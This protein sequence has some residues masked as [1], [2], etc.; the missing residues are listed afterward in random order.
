M[1]EVYSLPDGSQVDLSNYS[2]F[3]RINFLMENPNAKKLKG[4]A[5]SAGVMPKKKAQNTESKQ[6]S[7]SSG[8]QKYRLANEDDLEIMQKR[9]D[10]PPP[11]TYRRSNADINDLYGAQT[12]F[13]KDYQELKALLGKGD[14]KQRLGS[15]PEQKKVKVSKPEEIYDLKPNSTEHVDSLNEIARLKSKI[16]ETDSDLDHPYLYYSSKKQNQ[17][18]NFIDENYSRTEL[19]GLGVNTEDFDGFLN[20]NGYKQDYLDK[21]ERGLFSGQ[22]SNFMTGYDYKL[23][24]ELAKKRMLNL[25]MDNM[26]RRDYT[27]Q[28]LN[29]EIE[30]V[31]GNIKEK[32]IINR[33]L[34]DQNKTAK[35]IENNFP[36]VAQKLKDRDAENAK[37]YEESKK[38]SSDFWSWDTP[39]KIGRAGWYGMIDRLDQVSP[40]VYE[41]LGMTDVAEGI[42][43][44]AEQTQLSRPDNRGF[45]YASGKLVKYNG[46][47]YIV[48]S[49]GQVYDKDAKIR[50]TDLL[51][52]ST[53]EKI[54]SDSKY[55]PSDWAF[56]GQGAA[57]QT[58]N[59]MGDMIIQ[60]ALT[61]GVGQFGAIATETRLA[62][63][64]AQRA[65]KFS[66]F[67]NDTSN[68]LKMI[69]LQR[70]EGYSMIAQ[71]ALGY[72]QGY[73]ETLKA[74]RENGIT[75]G[76]A[77]KLASSAAQRLAVLYSVTGIINPQ[78]QV[79]ENLFGPKNIIKKAIDQYTKQG[80]KGFMQYLDDI[81]K[82]APKNMIG[83]AEEGGKEVIQENIQQVGEIGANKITNLEAGKKIMNEVMSG[84]D[85]VNTSILSFLSSGLISKMK[86]PDFH[87]PDENID[88][89]TSLST[90]AKNKKEFTK[91]IDGLVNQKVFTVEQADN[92]KKDVDIYADN[93]NKL[94]KTITPEAAMPVMRELDKIT[95]LENEKKSVDKAFHGEIDDKIDEIRQKI[96]DIQY[97]S[98]LKVKNK[99]IADAIKKGVAKGIEMKTF[100]STEETK[101]YLMNELNMPEK[102]ANDYLVNPGFALNS[103]TLKKYS[104]DADSISDKS[105]VIV[106]NESKTRD[107]GVI[108]HEFLH[109]V[110]QNTLK[111]NPEAQKLIG[112]AL[113]NELMKM[114]DALQKKGSKDSPVSGMFMQRLKQYIDKSV[115]LK[116]KE[117]ASYEIKLRQADGDPSKIAALK[118]AHNDMLNKIDGVMWEE[119]LTTYSDA[120]RRGHIKYEESTFTKLGD[121]IR[122][123][124][125]YLGIK[126]I[127]FNSG[128]DVYNFLKDYNHSVETGNWGKALTKMSNEG[129][130]INI[131]KE[132]KE[133]KEVSKPKEGSNFT[134]VAKFSL[135]ERKSSEDIKRDVNKTYNKEAWSTGSNSKDENPVIN[136]VMYDILNEYDYI[137]KGKAKGLGYANL[138]DFSEMD[139][140]SETQL[141][142]IPLIRNF[143]KEFFQKREE[144]KKELEA[145]GLD[146]NSKEFKDKVE[147]Q[148]EK[149]YQG[150]KGIVK[151][152]TDLNAYIN[153]QLANK[154]KD[155]LKT[156]NVTS[157]IFAE[158]IQGE[159]FKEKR[160]QDDFAGESGEESTFLDDSDSVFDAEQDFADEQRGLA[161]LLSDP[162]FK[163][164]DE[165]GKQ[166]DIETVPFGGFFVTEASDPTVAANRKLKTETDPVKIADLNRQIRDLD[167]GLQLQAKKDLTFEEKEELKALKS[168]KSYDL[169]T[170]MMVNTFEAL[171]MP[172]TPAKIISDEVGRE[173][174]RS[175]NIETLEYRNFKERLSTLSKTMARRMTF[176][177]GP[178][179]ESFMYDK[180]KL[181]Y[182][183]INHPVDP[184]TGESSY[185]SK[186]LP[187][188]LKEQD[189]KGD[190]RKIKDISRVKFLQSF[191]G[192][193]DATRIIKIYG[194]ENAAEELK[195]LEE[196]EVSEKDGG[197][198]RPTTYFDRRTALMELFGDVMVLQEARR[199]LR[200]PD[201]LERVA[202]RNV[203]LYNELKDDIIRAKVLNDMA[204]GKSDI[205]KFSLVEEI[206]VRPKPDYITANPSNMIG[207]NPMYSSKYEELFSNP[208]DFI[209]FSLAEIEEPAPEP[210]SKFK[211][212]LSRI[213]TDELEDYE[214]WIIKALQQSDIQDDDV[215]T[216][217][218]HT[219]KSAS[220]LNKEIEKRYSDLFDS[221]YDDYSENE[222]VIKEYKEGYIDTML[223]RSINIPEEEVHLPYWT[224]MKN[225]EKFR[226]K[227][228]EKIQ[229]QQEKA[230][231]QLADTTNEFDS[232]D[233][234]LF[235]KYL[236]LKDV[237]SNRYYPDGNENITRKSIKKS[238]YKTTIQPIQDYTDLDTLKEIWKNYSNNKSV[239]IGALYLAKKMNE[240]PISFDSNFIQDVDEDNSLYKFNRGTDEK[241]IKTLNKLASYSVK[242]GY[243]GSS[244][245]TGASMQ[246]AASQLSDGD[247][248][249]I[250]NKN[251]KIP[252][253]AVRY[254][255]KNIVE[256]AGTRDN[257]N[258]WKQDFNKI[259]F[260]A[261]ELPSSNK[262]LVLNQ[263]ETAKILYR[264]TEEDIRKINDEDILKGFILSKDINIHFE[265]DIYIKSK[266]ASRQLRRVLMEKQRASG[267][268]PL[269]IYKNGFNINEDGISEVLSDFD[270]D[271]LNQLTEFTS[272]VNIQL[273]FNPNSDLEFLET[274]SD[275]YED[276]KL[277]ELTKAYNLTIR[278][279]L[280]FE[281]KK[282][283]NAKNLN[284][285]FKTNQGDFLNLP[286]KIDYNI[287]LDFYD[288][289][290][291]DTEAGTNIFYEPVDISG[292]NLEL[293][294]NDQETEEIVLSNLQNANTVSIAGVVTNA[295][296]LPSKLKT[297]STENIESISGG[298]IEVTGLKELEN[299]NMEMTGFDNLWFS[300]LKK[301]KKLDIIDR[302]EY[303]EDVEDTIKESEV[304][305]LAE[306]VYYTYEDHNTGEFATKK[307]KSKPAEP[308]KFSLA[309]EENGKLSNFL[310]GLPFT[311][312]WVVARDIDN[313]IKNAKIADGTKVTFK[314][315][316]RSKMSDK[317]TAYFIIQKVAEGYNDFEFT[318]KKNANRPLTKQVLDAL[319]Y[320]SKKYQEIVEMNNNIE[321]TINDIIEENK[322]VKSEEKFSPE[323]AKNLGKN[324]GR[325][326]I[327]LPPEDEDFEGLL[328]TLASASGIRGE[329]QLEFLRNTLLKPYSDAMLNLMKARQTMYK[330]WTDLI[331]KKHKGVSKILKQDC[332]YGGY[333]YD[334]AVRVYLWKKAGYEIPGLDKKD[335][336]N[337]VEKV[338][339]DPKL[340][341]FA[342]DV[343]LLS[344]QANGWTKPGHNW[345]FGSVVGDINDIISKSNRAKYL[346]HWTKNVEKAFSKDNM[347]KIEAVYG[348]K[349]ATAL[350]N[351]LDRMK[352]GSNRVDGA[353][354]NLL[355][356]LNGAT[357]VTMFAN[358]RSALL[359]TL[360][361]I[362]F[363]NTS[364]NNI[365]K[366]GAALLNVPQYTK[367]FF[368]IWNSD[369]L[370]DRRSGLMNDVA[371]A[372]LAQLMND[373]RNKS[374]LDKFKAVNY[375]ILKQ[376]YAPTR[377]ADSFAIALGGAG[378]YRNR[379]NTYLKSGMTED[380]AKKATMRD[381][382][383]VSES[384]QQSADVSK[385]S[386]NQASV[387][388][389]LILAFQNTPLQYSRLIKRSAI[390]LIKGRGSVPNNIAKIL[391]YGAVQ[392]I[393]FNFMQNAL[394]SLL[395]DDEDEQKKARFDSAKVRALSGTMDTLLRGSGLQGAILATVK[396]II[397]KWYE[398]SG[399]PKGWGDVLLEAANLSPS[400]G[401]KAR[402]LAKSYKAV[403]YNKDEILYKGFSPDNV[404]A[405]EALTSLT[406]AS[407]NLPVDRLYVKT[408]NLSNALNSD[409]EAWERLAFFMGF[410]E[411]NLGLGK[412][413]N[414]EM[415]SSGSLKIPELKT[416]E[417]KTNELKM[418]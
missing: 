398:K 135:S 93:I 208:S 290:P 268:D 352:T 58:A 36:S 25:Y 40:V 162:T 179:I 69:P 386:M 130:K 285:E 159:G 22:G 31:S 120:L 111:D 207:D 367:D 234:S 84:D 382:Y 143:N 155:A 158:D 1:E 303:D 26:Q 413:K 320:K 150:K 289:D 110:L 369:Y 319:D 282:L 212:F 54:L 332:G 156:G 308:I 61:R 381:F 228:L 291:V 95:K 257:Q 339:T 198:L 315:P 331:N 28:D 253:L 43:L 360:G 44:N 400:I 118:A 248:Y 32:Q 287:S 298:N 294:F 222:W 72:T 263:L 164:V 175:P 256:M 193:D 280:S 18:D 373:P 33:S 92:L 62:L 49:R 148:D 252:V 189:E 151:E 313:A 42:R 47:D 284:I 201:F 215:N 418:P 88:N 188:R 126:D 132:N 405:L 223:N 142:M 380:E 29:Q 35:Y 105:Q 390:D 131:Q 97:E 340:R 73:E 251:S 123:V 310:E 412:N 117:I 14:Y 15:L 51:G 275:P 384:S 57:T 312:Q 288:S 86:L 191:Y 140:V 293:Y 302:G 274:V 124:L 60:A 152:N 259:E 300:Y 328:Y 269:E 30:L 19:E 333:L 334:Q 214:G 238:E 166:I 202:E 167:R 404:Y 5:K 349:Y 401:I 239:G 226:Q 335:I 236:F 240:K 283:E 341:K 392:N 225:D 218:L 161:V 272:D 78:T 361:A 82:N 220:E 265:N 113:T 296:K 136:R 154:M 114:H 186:K 343:S 203:N 317:S 115:E 391:Y 417:L 7:G 187:P 94:R 2:D 38:G 235:F 70:A 27:K 309:E 323:T 23:A 354:D 192:V 45:A 147:T 261:N 174:L 125:Q 389:R 4:V 139:F 267:A 337:L 305:K 172:D 378:F 227:E 55:A 149:G 76:E 379:I 258:L 3:E 98:E 199:L 127:K 145:K 56:S 336:F 327:Y 68:A 278:G 137:I 318:V 410:N 409:F 297:L 232:H 74:A 178:E 34:F 194:G 170:G 416:S 165:D 85:F 181:L 213:N 237:L 338:R 138:P 48:D 311:E 364:D 260:A 393:M 10:A 345:G 106:V 206:P 101:D 368:T 197:K 372:E 406:S 119:A 324:V 243:K 326:K 141:A 370:R 134:T 75:D 375:W 9:G 112:T 325:H 249:I 217:K 374:I 37:L 306:V 107:A 262:D 241:E 177:N 204:K 52:K 80:E 41:K 277:N 362:N 90:L 219:L 385:I 377:L 12:N 71:G 171:S 357:A 221:L 330:D 83:F 160:I 209:K 266:Y 408:Q 242:S 8:S 46:T 376:G 77:F 104:K 351:T 270:L 216:K 383:Q 276:I 146:P 205:V 411:W 231:Q 346:E 65:T 133:T 371:E 99:A 358:M 224:K 168:F 402:A 329:E 96:V 163:F 366:A 211:D 255:D 322:G 190:F 200:Q 230:L 397:V 387:K 129:A 295:I 365:L 183:V 169:S 244:W 176:K 307:L 304:F 184:I 17:E 271:V 20:K 407:T 348:R 121:T 102:D 355:N 182:D 100:S 394:F 122:R 144:Y 388:G 81:V 316:S 64:G 399:D 350:R 414:V 321:K 79:A 415:S 279:L 299:L 87:S 247:F 254:N 89:L 157:Q 229:L 210:Q 116:A 13:N 50:V 353:N 286:S 363:I 292:R 356:W 59:V 246:M 233:Y 103:K 109:G 301:V 6:A 180:W 281:A 185:A 264:N 344:K 53:Y 63:S 403:E 395:W 108:Q 153:S 66:S 273:G 342:D 396:N 16:Q 347:S 24:D 128:R 91:I 21:K 67:L 314:V 245:C 39:G 359:Q 196:P 250:A 11:S 195:Q 173:I